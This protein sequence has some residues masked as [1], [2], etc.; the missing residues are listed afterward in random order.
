MSN[1]FDESKI[2]RQGAGSSKGGQFAVKGNSA[3]KTG[4][5]ASL[6]DHKANLRQQLIDEGVLIE[7][8]AT[9]TWT[10]PNVLPTPR[11]R[12]P[13]DVRRTLDVSPTIRN[14]DKD[15]GAPQVLRVV[16]S[17]WLHQPDGKGGFVREWEER[18][19]TTQR[20]YDG[21]L[22]Q[23]VTDSRDQPIAATPENIARRIG[24]G[25]S[26]APYVSGE[27]EEEVTQNAQAFLDDYVAIDGTLWKKTSE[28]VYH[29][30]TFG[31]GGVNGST[32]L[33]IAPAD[34]FSQDGHALPE[35]VYPASEREAAIEAAVKTAEL[36]GDTDSIEKIRNRSDWIEVAPD[37]TPGQANTFAP[38]LDYVRPYEAQYTPDGPGKPEDIRRHFDEFKKQL[39]SVPGAVVDVPDG[40]GGTT[41]TVD[42]SKLSESQAEDYRTYLK[43]TGMGNR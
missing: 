39:L 17:G 2:R 11:H 13:R 26:D 21:G 31:L 12:K 18:I 43:I 27:T 22:Y 41:K 14:A 25:L 24:F 40:W 29:V 23:Q 4:L 5:S 33:S 28:P 19:V 8:P 16:T 3:P 7:A 34:A 35:H 38:R 15:G 1:V 36:R 42:P 20:A 30:Q 10:E 9:V 37:F 32:A 6:Q